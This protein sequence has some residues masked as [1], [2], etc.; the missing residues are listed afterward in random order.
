MLRPIQV[1]ALCLAAALLSACLNDSS[2]EFPAQ[3]RAVDVFAYAGSC[4]ALGAG[5]GERFLAASGD[6]FSASQGS[7]EQAARFRMQAADL[8]TYLLLDTDNHY[9]VSDGSALLRRA[10]LQSDTAVVDGVIEIDDN[11]VSEGEWDL[12]APEDGAGR[13]WLRHRLSGGFLS[14]SG[15]SATRSND[16]TVEFAQQS[17]CTDFPELSTDA[18]GEVTRTTFDDGTLFGFV[19]THSHLFTNF[20]F[21][22]GGIYHGAPFHRLGVEHALPNCSIPHGDEGRRDLLGYAFDNRN[23]SVSEIL[24]P[25][26][27]GS[28]PGFNHATDGY[29]DFTSWP[30]A[31]NSAT[32]Q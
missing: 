8:G 13:M 32:H 18:E 11:F 28:T 10:Q 14:N 5:G 3:P 6:G 20:G 25:L 23:L 15:I 9:L 27:A 16:N 12:I 17:G 2:D 1:P 26:A 24:G 4:V 7:P 31:R 19:E 21:A 22:G 30:D 29:P